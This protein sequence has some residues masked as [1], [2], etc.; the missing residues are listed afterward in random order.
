MKYNTSIRQALAWQIAVV[1]G[2]SDDNSGHY[3]R[4]SYSSNY[5]H[6]GGFRYGAY[7]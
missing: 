1:G 3:N 6:S 4:R 2:V 5:G 7:C